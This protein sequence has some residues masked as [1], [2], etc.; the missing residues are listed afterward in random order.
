MDLHNESNSYY[1]LWKISVGAEA[2]DV[3]ACALELGLF[4]QLA[5]GPKTIAEIAEHM[6]IQLRPAEVLAVT[7]AAIGVLKKDGD[8]YANIGDMEEFLVEGQAL[9]NQYTAF[10]RAGYVDPERGAKIK[11]AI[12]T[13]RPQKGAGWLD[14]ATGKSHPPWPFTPNAI[15]CASSGATVWRKR[16]IFLSTER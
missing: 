8:R 10:G 7:C 5:D 12:L 1:Q 16:S 14:K 6:G 15:I 3:L 4:T 9:Y 11:E 13:D 2:Q